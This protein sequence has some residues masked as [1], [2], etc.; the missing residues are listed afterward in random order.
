MEN[1]YGAVREGKFNLQ[2]AGPG[3]PT[4][5]GAG[6]SFIRDVRHKVSERWL[7]GVWAH[8]VRALVMWRAAQGERSAGCVAGASSSDGRNV[9][10][11]RRASVGCS[12]RAR[13]IG[14][15]WAGGRA[16]STPHSP[17]CA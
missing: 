1:G 9:W 14:V 4:G 5:R 12:W 15:V 13:L 8:K 6:Y 2:L 10:R 3:D 7:C 11:T 17:V 16:R